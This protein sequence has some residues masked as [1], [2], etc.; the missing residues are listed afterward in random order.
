MKTRSRSL[1][2]LL[3]VWGLHG[4]ATRFLP[5][6]QDPARVAPRVVTAPPPLREGEGQ[7]TLSTTS[8]RAR[9]ELIT[10]RTQV[11]PYQWG[12]GFTPR[13][14]NGYAPQTQYTLRPLCLTPCAVN[15]PL[16]THELLFTDVNMG[17]GRT[18]TAFVDVGATSS[19]VRHTMGRQTSSVGGL[20]GS[21]VMG[22]LGVALALAGGM[23]IGFQDAS[24]PSR[25]GLAVA[26]G[27]T[28]GIGAG[29][30]VGAT[31]LGFAS[32]P[33]LQ[34]GASTQWTP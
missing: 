18:S 11:E 10:A 5:P 2:A 17:S 22:G 30:G 1:A 27:V 34:P 8:G 33:T 9:V 3:G 16:G 28:L 6:P 29:L 7:V 14:Y 32:R 13:G 31:I 21:I 4:C 25:A 19:I 26:G 15:L 23:L 24:D 20:V 12:N